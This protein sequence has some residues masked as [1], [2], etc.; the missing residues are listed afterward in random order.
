[1]AS[2]GMKLVDNM[3]PRL[4]S[5]Y[6][7][8]LHSFTIQTPRRRRL[9]RERERQMNCRSFIWSHGQN[10]SYMIFILA[11]MASLASP[12][13][14]RQHLFTCATFKYIPKV[15]A[16]IDL[17]DL[18]FLASM[19]VEWQRLPRCFRKDS[20]LPFLLLLNEQVHEFQQFPMFQQTRYISVQ[21]S[22]VT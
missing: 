17:D 13:L 15:V 21:G 12:I 10:A 5:L 19:R 22:S 14:F 6:I 9:L 3:R 20:L 2:F 18:S 11:L 1:M 7:S 4:G 8:W 16:Q